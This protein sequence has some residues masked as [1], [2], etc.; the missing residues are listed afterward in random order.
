MSRPALSASRSIAIIDFLAAFPGR[1]F[2]LSEIAR[3][4]N[5][6]YGSC[7]AVLNALTLSGYLKR[8]PN[9]KSYVLGPALIAIGQS[10]LKSQPLFP[11]IQD[12]TRKLV[13]ELKLP[14][15]VSE[16]TTKVE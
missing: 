8:G 7:H 3:A 5:I 15:L 6:N 9:Q 16:L 10:A 14:V 4:A 13:R 11:R 1:G 2:T 12:A